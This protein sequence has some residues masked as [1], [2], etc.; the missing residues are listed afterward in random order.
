MQGRGLAIVTG[1]SLS[2]IRNDVNFRG[3]GVGFV[4]WLSDGTDGDR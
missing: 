1:V 2:V 3:K 4:G